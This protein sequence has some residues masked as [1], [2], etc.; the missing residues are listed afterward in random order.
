MRAAVDFGLTN[1][2]VVVESE[3]GHVEYVTVSTESDVDVSQ[4][5]R[6][7]GASGRRVS[8][9]SVIGVTGGQHR[10]LPTHVDGVVL[11]PVD[12]AA[13]PKFSPL[14]SLKFS[15]QVPP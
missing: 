7:I 4:L 2:D 3:S 6:A 5:R 15:P 13:F 10:R 14:F 11:P 1:I 9:F 8:D 12:E